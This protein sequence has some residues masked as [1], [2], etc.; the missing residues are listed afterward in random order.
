[1][2]KLVDTIETE[3]GTIEIWSQNEFEYYPPHAREDDNDE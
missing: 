1:M 3:Y 2:T